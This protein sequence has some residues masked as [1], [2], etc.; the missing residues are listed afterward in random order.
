MK[1]N[2][3]FTEETRIRVSVPG[4]NGFFTL[5]P[6]AFF[7]DN[8]TKAQYKKLLTTLKTDAEN[9]IENAE[10]ILSYAV[11]KYGDNAE[12]VLKSRGMFDRFQDL[13]KIASETEESKLSAAEKKAITA[14]N[15]CHAKKGNVPVLNYAFEQDGK[16]FSS[17]SF[18]AARYD[19]KK[20][21]FR[22]SFIPEDMET[23][24][25]GN[26]AGK[27]PNISL[28][29]DRVLKDPA[30]LPVTI[31]DAKTLKP[32]SKSKKNETAVYKAAR[33]NNDSIIVSCDYLFRAAALTLSNTLYIPREGFQAAYMRGNGYTVI[34]CPMRIRETTLLKAIQ[35]APR[36]ALISVSCDDFNR[37]I[38]NVSEVK[39][40]AEKD[41][42]ENEKA[43]E[44]EKPESGKNAHTSAESIISDTVPAA[45]INEPEK[46]VSARPEAAKAETMPAA[47]SVPAETEPAADPVNLESDISASGAAFL[48]ACEK[49]F[50]PEKVQEIV[51]EATKAIQEAVNRHTGK[52]FTN[53]ETAV[54]A[55]VSAS[56]DSVSETVSSCSASAFDPHE[57]P[58]DNH[59]YSMESF[60]H[61]FSRFYNHLYNTREYR[62]DLV[63]RFDHELTKTEVGILKAF[64][65]YRHDFVSSDREAAAF[66]LAIDHLEYCEKES[67]ASADSSIPENA[68]SV[69]SAETEETEAAP[70]MVKIQGIELYDS[71]LN[72]AISKKEYL[73]KGHS[74]YGI[75]RG[76]R[77]G[78]KAVLVF[79]S[80]HYVP[81]VSRGHFAFMDAER[82]KNMFPEFT[83]EFYAE[84]VMLTVKPDL[85]KAAEA[86]PEATPEAVQEAV[87]EEVS[88]EVQ[89]AA[90]IPAAQ[91]I[92]EAIRETGS[93]A[94]P[95]AMPSADIAAHA[96]YT[97]VYAAE[98]RRCGYIPAVLCSALSGMPSAFTGNEK[99]ASVLHDIAV[100][101]N[102][103][104]LPSVS[105]IAAS[106][107]EY[108]RKIRACDC[109]PFCNPPP[110]IFMDS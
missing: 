65:E 97:P 38:Y 24:P 57:V 99:A 58:A 22:G 91:G 6:S 76:K 4:S 27:R 49:H 69:P 28:L 25:D 40:E 106:S 13:Q 5:K 63:Y 103:S 15:N 74:V 93:S 71:R 84:T 1:E 50:T 20:E 41:L 11:F 62:A 109:I 37:V 31:P 86:V 68:A 36:H 98:T 66:C 75:E 44:T 77:G 56:A 9:A 89:E 80:T 3:I 30:F 64:N 81:I 61:I 18:I 110:M 47:E 87:P 32:W 26:R 94:M 35:E 79:K 100:S 54:S 29:F 12:T 85:P 7:S 43:P 45:A 10:I 34:L 72:E 19:G 2:I 88:E 60:R 59:G 16:I 83:S 102:T 107:A 96:V 92:Q 23:L 21:T 95:S 48:A 53:D 105:F 42:S 52:E 78:Y 108:P 90:S 67:A 14:F 8:V 101:G 70:R 82:L 55:S 51:Q 73:V 33:E 17:D 104:A 39:Q 46:A